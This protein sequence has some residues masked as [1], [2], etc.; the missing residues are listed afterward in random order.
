MFVN[1]LLPFVLQIK[2]YAEY[3]NHTNIRLGDVSSL[4][5]A[6]CYHELDKNYLKSINVHVFMSYVLCLPLVFI[7]LLIVI[8]RSLSVPITTKLSNSLNHPN[9]V[10]MALT[11]AFLHFFCLGLDIVAVYFMRHEKEL[12]DIEPHVDVRKS[13]NFFGI[14]ITLTFN[15]AVTIMM[16]FCLLY[17]HCKHVRRDANG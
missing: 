7:I 3:N 6:E 1:E 10:G 4:A 16:M 14:A 8:A 5:Q 11:G 17:L 13:I 9:V 12:Q 2:L 15:L